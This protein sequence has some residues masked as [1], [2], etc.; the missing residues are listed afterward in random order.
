MI[1]SNNPS[2][3]WTRQSNLTNKWHKANLTQNQD[4]CINRMWDTILTY[5][6]TYILLD[7]DENLEEFSWMFA[8]MEWKWKWK[9]FFHLYYTR[10][11]G[12]LRSLEADAESSKETRHAAYNT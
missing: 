6:L 1:Q 12:P 8:V 5:I 2:L 4:G 10:A 9:L 7:L 3:V 11:L